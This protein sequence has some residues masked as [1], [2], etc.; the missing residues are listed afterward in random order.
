LVWMQP[1]LVE[2]FFSVRVGEIHGFF[3]CSNRIHL[4]RWIFVTEPNS[5]TVWHPGDR[6]TI[7]WRRERPAFT[8]R[9]E[10]IMIYEN[11][12]RSSALLAHVDESAGAATV[13]LPADL[14]LG[15][16]AVMIKSDISGRYDRGGGWPESEQFRVERR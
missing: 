15:R 1:T 6:V 3:G 9:I 16:Y 13:T 8:G 12:I 11:E 14:R 4:Y 5:R 10:I 2:G 7:R